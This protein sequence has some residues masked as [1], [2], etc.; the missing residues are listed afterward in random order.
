MPRNRQKRKSLTRPS[1][2]RSG[3]NMHE[4]ALMNIEKQINSAYS[5]LASHTKRNVSWFTF[6]KDTRRIMLLLAELRYLINECKKANN[7]KRYSN[8]KKRRAA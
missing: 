3:K 6:A 4:L 7:P 2:I 1:S 8:Q 5:T